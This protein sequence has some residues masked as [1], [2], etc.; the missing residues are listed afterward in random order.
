[1]TNERERNDGEHN[2]GQPGPPREEVIEQPEERRSDI[3]DQSARQ[4]SGRDS[5]VGSGNE[6]GS[7]RRAARAPSA[8]PAPPHLVHAVDQQR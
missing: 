1:M 7:A 5:R 3:D 2:L 6:T 8:A 4:T